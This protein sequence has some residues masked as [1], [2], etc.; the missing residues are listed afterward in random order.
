MRDQYEKLGDIAE[1][2]FYDIFLL[3]YFKKLRG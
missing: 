1:K 2:N 3:D